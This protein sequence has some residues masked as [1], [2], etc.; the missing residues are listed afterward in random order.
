MKQ[1]GAGKVYADISKERI[2][3]AE[4][5]HMHIGHYKILSNYRNLLNQDSTSNQ[6]VNTCIIK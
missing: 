4:T 1:F 2:Q 5:D 3:I 6:W